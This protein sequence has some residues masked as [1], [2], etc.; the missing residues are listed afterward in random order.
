M[1]KYDE[2]APLQCPTCRA[3]LYGKGRC[4]KLDRV[5]EIM[6]VVLKYDSFPPGASVDFPEDLVRRLQ[7]EQFNAACSQVQYLGTSA[8]HAINPEIHFVGRAQR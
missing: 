4:F 8:E 6:Q 7:I 5:L 1:N 2:D 3:R